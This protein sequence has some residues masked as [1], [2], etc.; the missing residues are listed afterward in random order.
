MNRSKFRQ[1]TNI[2]Y[3]STE[4]EET[5]DEKEESSPKKEKEKEE[6]ELDDNSNVGE[7]FIRRVEVFYCEVCRIY[8]PRHSDHERV[9]RIHCRTKN[10]LR[11]YVRFGN[12]TL[13]KKLQLKESSKD[14][15]V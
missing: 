15:K 11:C 3:F 1:L 4:G 9:L 6:K 7:E 10:H 2:F 5:K 14:E 12:D 8:L 13:L